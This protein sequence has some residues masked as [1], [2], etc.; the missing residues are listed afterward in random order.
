MKLNTKPAASEFYMERRE[1]GMITM[2]LI[3]KQKEQD[4]IT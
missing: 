1:E 2:A 4:M 3:W